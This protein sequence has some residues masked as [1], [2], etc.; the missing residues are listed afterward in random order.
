MLTTLNGNVFLGY[1]RVIHCSHCNN[2]VQEQIVGSTSEG[3]ICSIPIRA[4]SSDFWTTARC[5]ICHKDSP[6][7]SDPSFE[8][9]AEAVKAN[10]KMDVERFRQEYE[11]NQKQLHAAHL[12]VGRNQTKEYHESLNWYGKKVH[13]SR[14]RRFGFSAL[15]EFVASK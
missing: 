9:Y 2:E 1:G 5:P 11:F 12:V 7:P 14:L 13:R 3:G 8:K 6:S 10:K 4:M 15:A